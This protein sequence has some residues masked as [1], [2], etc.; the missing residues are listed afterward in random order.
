MSKSEIETISKA[1]TKHWYLDGKLHRED[2][3]AIEYASGTK[4]W[5]LNGQRHREEGPAVEYIN[6]TRRW[7]IKD[8]LHREDGPAIEWNTGEKWWYLNGMRLSQ[9]EYVEKIIELKGS[10]LS[11]D[12]LFL[13]E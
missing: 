7:Y 6:G 13:L 3:P 11:A 9:R 8:V 1:G 10:F 2:G 12:I 5:F 4:E